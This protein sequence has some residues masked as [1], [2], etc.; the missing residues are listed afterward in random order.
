MQSR[1]TLGD[2]FTSMFARKMQLYTP[3]SEQ[4]TNQV[5]PY[6]YVDDKYPNVAG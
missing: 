2:F 5:H 6:I 3:T 4:L 1:G